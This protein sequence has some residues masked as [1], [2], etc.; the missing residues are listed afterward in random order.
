MSMK[1]AKWLVATLL[2]LGVLTYLWGRAPN[3]I[4]TDVPV[5]GALTQ[6]KA[7]SD[8]HPVSYT[9]LTLPTKRIV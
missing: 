7:P 3:K 4:S 8:C 9:H 6:V 1:Q 5:T 2:I